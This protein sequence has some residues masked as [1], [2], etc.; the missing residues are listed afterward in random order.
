[1][2]PGPGSGTATQ[3]A[4]MLPA[5]LRIWVYVTSAK[6]YAGQGMRDIDRLNT[7]QQAATPVVVFY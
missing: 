2:S 6:H 4:G 7:S 5:A 1:M 3:M